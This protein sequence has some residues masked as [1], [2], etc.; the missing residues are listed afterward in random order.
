M[1][2]EK[3]RFKYSWVNH[4]FKL[5][6][7]TANLWQALLFSG[8]IYLLQTDLLLNLWLHILPILH[9]EQQLA[10]FFSKYL[11]MPGQKSYGMLSTNKSVLNN[12]DWYQAISL[13]VSVYMPLHSTW[14]TDGDYL[15]VQEMDSRFKLNYPFCAFNADNSWLSL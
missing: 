1:P 9:S 6:H 5:W 15:L 10:V 14:T 3:P 12:C 4:Y 8:C 11:Q 2:V 13:F 7:N